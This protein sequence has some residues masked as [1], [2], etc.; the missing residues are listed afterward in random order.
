ME[1]VGDTPAIWGEG[2]SVLAASGEPTLIV[3]PDGVGKTTLLQRYAMARVGVGHDLL[4]LPVAE[5][6]ERVLYVAADRPKQGARSLWRMVRELK[7]SD[8]ARIKDRVVVW[9]GPL[10]FDVV[11]E[12]E[13]LQRLG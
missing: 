3:G 9:R 5:A 2:D 11:G 10:P 1:A 7:G 13:R 6:N 4:G 8:H 12:P